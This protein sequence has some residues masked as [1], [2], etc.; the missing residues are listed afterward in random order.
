MAAVVAGSASGAAIASL[1]LVAPVNLRVVTGMI[2]AS[3]VACGAFLLP[4]RMP[5]INRE[6]EQGLLHHGPLEWAAL[7]GAL[8]GLG[9]T[10]R[11]GYWIW[12]LIPITCFILGA[13]MSGSIVWATYAFTR[14]GIA[15]SL[16]G[17]MHRQPD[18]ISMIS[19]WLLR[20]RLRAR[21]AAGP[22]AGIL[23]FALG[24]WLAY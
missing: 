7:N 15:V 3:T 20:L 14:L 8:L 21:A 22:A 5:Q 1:A 2:L 23:A 4:T 19:G 17:W 6:T 12:Y 24:I 10:S 9:F 16:A 18:Q 13:P 11:V